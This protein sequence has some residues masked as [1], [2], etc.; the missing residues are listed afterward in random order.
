MVDLDWLQF[1]SGMCPCFFTCP[2]FCWSDVPDSSDAPG[3]ILYSVICVSA[4]Q[5]ILACSLSMQSDMCTR[6]VRSRMEGGWGRDVM[7]TTSRERIFLGLDIT[8]GLGVQCLSAEF[9]G[10]PAI[11][12]AAVRKNW[13]ACQYLTVALRAD[14]EFGLAAVTE[15]GCIVEYL[16]VEL[17]ADKER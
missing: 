16:S 17:R 12:L 13:R 7:D 1:E 9:R 6:N 5:A 14:K 4:F 10:D 3:V 2:F 15:D 8:D 11:G